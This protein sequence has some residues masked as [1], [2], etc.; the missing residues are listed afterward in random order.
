M[1]TVAIAALACAVLACVKSESKPRESEPPA[2]DARIATGG[3]TV[4]A[5][6]NRASAP[7]VSKVDCPMMAA[8]I[9]TVRDTRVAMN[10]QAA[11]GL[12]LADWQ[13]VPDECRDG[14]WHMLG[15]QLL[16][17]EFAESIAAGDVRFDSPARALADGLARDPDSAE[18][19]VFVAYLSA[20]AP[21]D[22]PALPSGACDLVGAGTDE[23]SRDR[24]SYVCG[25]AALANRD[26]RA[27]AEAFGA[28]ANRRVYPDLE[29]RTA[30]ALLR[31]DDRDGA[32]AAA[33]RVGAAT[34]QSALA[35]GATEAEHAAIAARAKKLIASL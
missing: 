30:I 33:E 28:V 9:G 12:A 20:I 29:L 15:A 10:P 4:P 32:R 11:F 3:P 5:D 27:A 17:T 23:A 25:H 8:L 34:V 14:R 24:H 1:R 22:S 7:P 35:F 19:L 26:P 18:L 6:A 2:D 21:D 13:A 16:R 31:S